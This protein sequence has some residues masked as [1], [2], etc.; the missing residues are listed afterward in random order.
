[1]TVEEILACPSCR[2]SLY[3]NNRYFKCKEC[4]RDYPV[5]EGDIIDFLFDNTKE[6]IHWDK[7]A[8][9]DH[10][11]SAVSVPKGD[12][13][14]I[15]VKLPPML[16]TS[17]FEG[18]VHVDLGCGYGRTL[19]YAMMTTRPQ[20]SIGV[21]ISLTML[22]KTR[23]YARYYNVNPILIRGDI[24][25]LPLQ[26]SIVDVIYSS[27]VLF[28]IQKSN[29]PEIVSEVARVLK[30]EGT[31][32]FERSF[33]GWLNPDGFQTRVIT[34]IFSNILSPA[35]VR[36]YSYQ[37]V[38]S[39]FTAGEYFTC[40]DIHP[41][42]YK[43]LPKAFFKYSLPRRTKEIINSINESVSRILHFKNL[44]VAGWSIEGRK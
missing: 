16:Q 8:E 6:G 30:K 25:I 7:E 3:R 10:I 22:K 40:L 31:V 44:F 11:H 38:R 37:E 27:G 29:I 20:V 43:I 34:G 18:M 15:F 32:V 13:S 24:S 12:I 35:W 21:D 26:S 42:G 33:P 5:L 19:I 9:T 17:K 1:M 14:N 39:I 41:E 2:N 23:E 36:T 28:H 4:S